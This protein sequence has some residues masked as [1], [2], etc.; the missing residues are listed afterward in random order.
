M[1]SFWHFW[2][3]NGYF[4]VYWTNTRH[5][6]TYFNAFHMVIPNRVMKFHNF[7]IFYT[8]C[9][10]FDMSSALAC[11][12]V[13]I[14]V[15]VRFVG[16]PYRF[17]RNTLTSVHANLQLCIT[18]VTI[19]SAIRLDYFQCKNYELSFPPHETYFIQVY[20]TYDELWFGNV[21]QITIFAF[22]SRCS[23]N[24]C[25]KVQVRQYVNRYVNI[26]LN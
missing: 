7:D 1:F 20:N 11:R 2:N 3:C 17:I 12:V 14:N 5:V 25:D 24:S 22:P 21:I 19:Q 16:T 23:C 4:T 13:S 15:N 26:Y 9:Y 6:G 8:I 18:N 10:I